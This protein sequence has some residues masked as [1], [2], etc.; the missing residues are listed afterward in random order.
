[1]QHDLLLDG[2]AQRWPALDEQ[3]QLRVQVMHFCRKCA[4]FCAAFSANVA[5]FREFFDL[6]ESLLRY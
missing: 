2:F 1:M 3:L 4:G 5:G 6:F